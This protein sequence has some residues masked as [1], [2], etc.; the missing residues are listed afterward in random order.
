M[1]AAVSSVT[2]SFRR[3]AHAKASNP[4]GARG[5]ERAAERR[6][7]FDAAGRSEQALTS[8]AVARVLCRMPASNPPCDKIDE[9]IVNDEIDLDYQLTPT[10][11]HES[12]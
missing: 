8:A 9:S 5:A 11:E 4:H 10:V 6:G 7:L 1:N 12:A 2:N 3:F